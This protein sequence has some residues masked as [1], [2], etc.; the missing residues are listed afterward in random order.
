MSNEPVPSTTLRPEEG[1]RLFR[2]FGR[3]RY[4]GGIRG[5][6]VFK[7]VEEVADVLEQIVER[8]E[9]LSDEQKAKDERLANAERLLRNGRELFA[10]FA[11]TNGTNPVTEQS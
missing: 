8:L 10:Y 3:M 1:L 11:G 9:S 6:D 7:T 5:N 4:A 2:L